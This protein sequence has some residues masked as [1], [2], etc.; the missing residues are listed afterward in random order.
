MARFRFRAVLL[1]VGAAFVP[2]PVVY[3][4]DNPKDSQALARLIDQEIGAKLAA[5]K[6]TAADDAD[7]ATFL[8]RLYLDLQGTLPPADKAA[9]FLDSKD[10]DKRA[11]LIAEL[12]AAEQYGQNLSDIWYGL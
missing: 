9:A 5:Q 8:R 2:A 12:L 11:K 1:I 4:A 6:F 10:P 7:D 3:G